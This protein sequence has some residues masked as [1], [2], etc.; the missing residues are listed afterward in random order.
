MEIRSLIDQNILSINF[1]YD[2]KQIEIEK[3]VCTQEKKIIRIPI[4]D[5]IKDSKKWMIL[6]NNADEKKDSSQLE[7]SAPTFLMIKKISDLN[8]KIGE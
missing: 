2:G 4:T 8:K 5:A 7:I 3:I 6:I 1:N